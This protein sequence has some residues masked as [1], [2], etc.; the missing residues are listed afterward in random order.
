M[1]TTALPTAIRRI[2]IALDASSESVSALE[3]CA[4]LA[5]RMQAELQGLFVEDESVLRLAEIPLAREL[6]YFSAAG[7]PVSRESMELQFRAQAEQ[8]QIAFSRAAQGARIGSSFRRLRGQVGMV[9]SAAAGEVDLVVIGGAGWSVGSRSRLS[10]AALQIISSSAPLLLLPKCGIPEPVHLIVF[11]NGTQAAERGIAVARELAGAG[12]DG[13]TV[14]APSGTVLPSSFGSVRS[15]DGS[16]LPTRSRIFDPSS[17]RNLL[18]A[19]QAERGGV[20]VLGGRELLT[21]LP[22]LEAILFDLEMPVLLVDRVASSA[23]ADQ[24]E[25]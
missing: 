5:A 21:S 18:R 14:L 6:P 7:I 15:A 9:L 11:F 10:A 12:M 1:S 20:L 19:L 23:E 22:P 17:D 2:L 8:I 3:T 13:I 25:R 16:P 24:M 4:R